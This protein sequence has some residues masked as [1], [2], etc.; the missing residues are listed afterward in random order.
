ALAGDPRRVPQG[1][2]RAHPAGAGEDVPA[3]AGRA[4]RGAEGGARAG[5]EARRRGARRGGAAGAERT[6][7]EHRGVVRELNVER[8]SKASGGRKPPVLPTTRGVFAPRSPLCPCRESR[9]D[10]DVISWPTA[11]G[12]RS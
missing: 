9:L 11:S 8:Q 7:G 1:I 3:A 4:G 5:A 12:S 6:L 2:A 10:G